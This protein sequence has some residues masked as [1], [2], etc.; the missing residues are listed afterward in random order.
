MTTKGQGNER[1]IDRW[2]PCEA[3]D[4]ASRT[5]AGSGKN[6]KAI[7]PWFASR[8]I[9]QA[10]AAALTALLPDDPALRDAVD[11]AVRQ[12]DRRSMDALAAK[13]EAHYGRKPVVLD[14][15]SGRGIMP[16]EAARAGAVSVG[17]DLSPVATLA[18]KI[19][20]DWP[21]RDWSSEPV[22]PYAKE[23]DGAFEDMEDRVV[24][25][26]RALHAEIAERVERKVEPYYPRNAQGDFPWGYVWAL[27]MPCDG[28]KRR[29]PL[30]GSLVL[31]HPYKRTNDAG[32]SLLIE[33][34]GDT[35]KAVVEDGIPQQEPT[36]SS[37]GARKGKSAR[38]PFPDCRHVHSLET[39]KRKG[40]A[41][42][43][44]DVLVA[45]GDIVIE[46]GG[47]KREKKRKLFR[48]VTPEEQ[49]AADIAV[50]LL[51]PVNGLTVVPDET[52]PDG[53]VHTIQASG[54][55]YTCFGDLMP[56]RQAMQFAAYA[57]AIRECHAEM[58]ERGLSKDYA[59]AQTALACATFVRR[60]KYATR[61]ASLQTGGTSAGATYNRTAVKHVFTN[62]AGITF[63]FDYFETGPGHGPA[64]WRGLA[65]TGLEPFSSHMLGRKAQAA[66]IRRGNAMALP[67]RDGTVD[68]VV[69]DPPY[70]DMIEYA[71][72]SDLFYV[73]LKRILAGT[74][75]DLF[76]ER[77]T[78]QDKDNEIIVRRVYNGG[79][80]HDKDFY[81]ASL[82]R[83]FREARRV[84]RPDG[85]LV[86]VFG[87]SDPDAW[88]RLLAALHDAGFVV[89]SSWP[90]RTESANTGVASI[91]ITVTIGCRVASPQRQVG[92]ADQVD[93][94]VID[95]VK[96]MVPQWEREG[97]AL[98]DQMM[99][100]YGPAME[101]YG[102]Y[103]R[104]LRP[105][106]TDASLEGY[107]L[108][109]RRAVRDAT[110]LKLDQMPL[111]T[112][113]PATRVAVFWMRAYGRTEVA[114]GEA[115]FLAQLDG[116]RIEALRDAILSEGRAG[117][118]LITDP[119]ASVTPAS[120]TFELVRAMAGAWSEGGTEAVAAALVAADR[121]A[122]DEHVWAV[123]GELVSQLPAADAVSKALTSIQRNRDAVAALV[124][125]TGTRAHDGGQMTLDEAAR[126]HEED[127]R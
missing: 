2:F 98:Q 18:G 36:F 5:P 30:L 94:E 68:A 38:C 81:E 23:Q 10:R 116:L 47:T 55:G 122:D 90:S 121:L 74:Q 16:L 58:I 1:M 71:D 22:F 65:L 102:R 51:P 105:D 39:V 87:H 108:L 101:V 123:V 104:V 54:Y 117:F 69:T 19:L 15:F 118:R 106:G 40:Q 76:D 4:E 78:L 63:Q 99:A 89:T 50:E 28:C 82:A 44:E 126:G 57:E 7:F 61:G 11:A 60:L 115:L 83:A 9:A 43:Y 120:S 113:D 17:I 91:K 35:W 37:S 8:P 42:Q 111:E 64:T 48:A 70:Y 52:I 62:E 80:R 86:V 59:D 107:L 41:K 88:K 100:A 31:R 124:H 6:E 85:H 127:Q 34:R 29:F 45:A 77:A 49:Q 96:A 109:A 93:G 114:K 95:A 72:A 32:Q 21:M 66:K 24:V 33:T 20:A 97:L 119:P 67:F 103:S 79:V 3:V 84:L 46:G 73:W 110:A 27:T 125:R 112:F 56:P 25:D 53:N 26:A 75:P 12:G 92:M 14:P 13:V